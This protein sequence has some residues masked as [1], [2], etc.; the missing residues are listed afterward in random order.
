MAFLWRHRLT[1]FLLLP[2][3]VSSAVAVVVISAARK[4]L[5]PPRPLPPRL[6]AANV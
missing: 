4:T 2:V 6:L 3:P 1:V 5:P